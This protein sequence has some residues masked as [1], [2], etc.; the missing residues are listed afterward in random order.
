MAKWLGWASQ[1]QEMYNNYQEFMG[2]NLGWV[3]LGVH[4]SRSYY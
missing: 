3:E 2:L 1:G 4:H